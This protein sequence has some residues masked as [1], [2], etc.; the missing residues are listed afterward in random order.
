MPVAL[1]RAVRFSAFVAPRAVH[2]AGSEICLFPNSR[3]GAARKDRQR[4][5]ATTRRLSA[6]CWGRSQARCAFS[7]AAN[8]TVSKQKQTRLGMFLRHAALE[9][10]APFC[11]LKMDAAQQRAQLFHRDLK[12]LCTGLSG[13]DC[14]RAGLKAFRPNCKSTSVPI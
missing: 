5:C 10:L 7:I 3:A 14:E 4:S 13:G 8:Q 6:E 12:P 2:A 11:L 9:T 1:S